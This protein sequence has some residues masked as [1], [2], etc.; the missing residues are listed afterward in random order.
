MGEII[1]L[2]LTKNL[3]RLWLAYAELQIEFTCYNSYQLTL[4]TLHGQNHTHTKTE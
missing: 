3:G 1:V 4:G 2:L